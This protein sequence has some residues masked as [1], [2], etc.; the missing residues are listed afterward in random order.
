MRPDRRTVE[1][2][3]TANGHMDPKGQTG[4][5][6]KTGAP[7]KGHLEPKGA[8]QSYRADRLG[9]GPTDQAKTCILSETGTP[10]KEGHGL[11]KTMQL[12]VAAHAQKESS[13][14]C[15]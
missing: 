14:I 9:A 5:L 12:D 15:S 1:D 10:S 2:R 11:A 6:S 13:L 8:R 7:P 3:R 4:V